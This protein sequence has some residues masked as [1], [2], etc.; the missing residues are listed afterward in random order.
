MN[1][2]RHLCPE[3]ADAIASGVQY[4][5]RLGSKLPMS[6]LGEVFKGLNYHGNFMLDLPPVPCHI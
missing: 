1:R 6:V 5:R 4:V 3:E 2:G